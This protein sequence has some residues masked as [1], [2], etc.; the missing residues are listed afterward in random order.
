MLRLHVTRSPDDVKPLIAVEELGLPYDVTFLDHLPAVGADAAAAPVLTSPTDDRFAIFSPAAALLHL[1]E[2]EPSLLPQV[3]GA[4][5]AA[6]QWLAWEQASLGPLDDHRCEHHPLVRPQ[7]SAEG[8]RRAFELLD[9]Q[10]ASRP[11]LLGAFSVA[12]IGVWPWAFA[13]RAGG[14]PVGGLRHLA[15]W[16]EAVHVRPAVQ[17]AC[18]VHR[19]GVAPEHGRKRGCQHDAVEPAAQGPARERYAAHARSPGI[20]RGPDGL[21]AVDEEAP[22]SH[23]AE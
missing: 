1:A 13:L 8:A 11:F 9:R 20:A 22:R 6:V 4:R 7:L 17:R 2:H 23:A 21:D 5:A 18:G 19:R 10:L 3:P 14:G 12:D 16:L 15:A